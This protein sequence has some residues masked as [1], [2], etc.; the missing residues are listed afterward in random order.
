M[1]CHYCKR[2]GQY[3]FDIGIIIS[4]CSKHINK[5]TKKEQHYMKAQLDQ[6][7]RQAL[8]ELK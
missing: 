5:A 2:K 4:V 1:K 6:A 7:R 3:T 8:R